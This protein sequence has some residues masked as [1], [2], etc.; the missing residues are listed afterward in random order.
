MSTWAAVLEPLT[1]VSFMMKFCLMCLPVP[2]HYG[3]NLDENV[4]CLW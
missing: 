3:T 2:A 1:K 4:W